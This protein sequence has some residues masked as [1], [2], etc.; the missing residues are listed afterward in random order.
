MMDRFPEAFERFEEVVD[1][2]SI[3]SF[4]ELREEFAWWAGEKWFNTSRQL[5]A[6]ST[7]AERLGLLP[8][9]V[10]WRYE[11]VRVR[12]RVLYRYRDIRTGRFIKRR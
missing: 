12:G 11:S 8:R 7:E 10:L 1:V 9:S 4:G 6:L 3:A 2:D 5:H